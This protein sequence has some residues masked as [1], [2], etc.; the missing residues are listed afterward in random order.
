MT[1][2]SK[3]A[4]TPVPP[5]WAMGPAARRMTIR[6]IADEVSD[7]TGIP[8]HYILGKRRFAHIAKARREVWLI[9]HSNGMSL[10]RIA[11][12]TGHHHTSVLAG[13]RR[14]RAEAME[15]GKSFAAKVRQATP[16]EAEQ[17]IETVSGF[18]SVC[19]GRHISPEKVATMMA[20]IEVAVREEAARNAEVAA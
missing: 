7:R 4:G 18:W 2:Q 13:I 20:L 15:A 17:T 14:A 1:A 11:E 5:A 16:E 6:E 19:L 12:V 9:A 8:V 3:I 10:P